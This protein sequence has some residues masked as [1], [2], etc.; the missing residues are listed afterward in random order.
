M[1]DL[2]KNNTKRFSV[3][4]ENS[5]NS[6]DMDINNGVI[7]DFEYTSDLTPKLFIT[8]LIITIADNGSFDSDDE[9]GGVQIN[10]GIRF[11]TQD[12]NFNRTYLTD[13]ISVNLDFYFYTDKVSYITDFNGANILN[14]NLDYKQD[15][16]VINRFEKIGIEL[17]VDDYSG[18]NLFKCRAIGYYHE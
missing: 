1:A 17:G 13:S 8:N 18:L 5:L 7:Q 6:Q 15:P 11:Y 4:L 9:F 16:I 10:N 14:V 2:S 12:R 3:F